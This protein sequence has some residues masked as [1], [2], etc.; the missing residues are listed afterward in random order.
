M[1]AVPSFQMSGGQVAFEAESYT[2]TSANG[3]TDT[4]TA[5]STSGVSGGISMRVGPDT[6][7]DPSWTSSVATTAPRMVYYVNFTDTGTFTVYIRGNGQ[8]G[9]DT[10]NSCWA[11]VDDVPLSSY[12]AFPVSS[13]AW[14][15]IPQ[16]LTVS[17]TGVHTFTIWGREDGFRADK[18]V[19]TKG[20]APTLDGPSQSPIN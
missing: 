1:C 11:G 18:I 4:W 2:S 16:S 12:F 8:D 19:I 3:S 6:D 7:N 5:E 17:T 10:D 14:D 15:W 20:A 13:S 9:N